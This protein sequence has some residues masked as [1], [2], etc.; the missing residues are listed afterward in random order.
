MNNTKNL[1]IVVVVAVVVVAAIVGITKAGAVP[2]AGRS[3]N[4]PSVAG[5]EPAAT[6]Q[7]LVDCCQN[8]AT[9]AAD[10]QDKAPTNQVMGTCT[11]AGIETFRTGGLPALQG[12][13]SSTCGGAC[14]TRT[15]CAAKG[16]EGWSVQPIAKALCE[17]EL[18]CGIAAI[19]E[20]LC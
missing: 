13:I 17:S 10:Y 14:I 15:A 20:C 3:G 5:V 12:Y 4:P 11:K 1:T 9:I 2:G 16:E 6:L 18:A 8:K 19:Y 7:N